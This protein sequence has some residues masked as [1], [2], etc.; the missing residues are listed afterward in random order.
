MAEPPKRDRTGST[1]RQTEYEPHG[2]PETTHSFV[3]SAWSLV[4]AIIL[5]IVVIAA[6]WSFWPEGH[7]NPAPAG[8]PANV[9]P[10]SPN[11]AQT[12]K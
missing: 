10:T 5:L 1:D 2:R 12:I 11:P 4:T 9:V 8:S 6:V 7:T 3:R